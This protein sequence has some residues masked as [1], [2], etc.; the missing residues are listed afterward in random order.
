MESG[1]QRGCL[2][3]DG[4]PAQRESRGSSPALVAR[5]RPR[6][7]RQDIGLR[8]NGTLGH[9]RAAAYLLNELR[10]LPGV[11]VELQEHAGTHVHQFIPLVPFVYRTT[12]V[13]ARL[14]GKS[15]DAILLDAHSST[16]ST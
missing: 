14:P 6:R 13:V 9:A 10:K 7:R 2:W 1:D 8:V 11:E 3:A 16:G 15:T 5:P 12:N 4:L